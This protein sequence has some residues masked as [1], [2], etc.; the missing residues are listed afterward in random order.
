MKGASPHF[1]QGNHEYGIDAL[2]ILIVLN[3][4][5]WH[6]TLSFIKKKT[7]Q[8]TVALTLMDNSLENALYSEV[9][10]KCKDLKKNQEHLGNVCNMLY[11]QLY[12]SILIKVSTM[13]SVETGS[14]CCPENIRLC[15][16]LL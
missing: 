7:R 6:M 15:L 2:Y 5:H 3:A 16:F 4:P 13:N 10:V 12:G 9:L 14:R 11:A 1:V 8:R